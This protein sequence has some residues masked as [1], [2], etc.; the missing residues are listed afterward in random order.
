MFCIKCT[1][2]RCLYRIF[3][4]L[5]F[6]FISISIERNWFRNT[7]CTMWICYFNCFSRNS[8]C[9]TSFWRCSSFKFDHCSFWFLSVKIYIKIRFNWRNFCIFRFP[10]SRRQWLPNNFVVG[11]HFFAAYLTI[12]YFRIYR[13]RNIYLCRNITIRINRH[14]FN[15][16]SYCSSC[17]LTIFP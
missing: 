6:C 10:Y 9:R 7:S 12:S 5:I 16:I 15:R 11:L 2:D 17:W 14:S 13:Y 3:S 4:S 8:C 1:T